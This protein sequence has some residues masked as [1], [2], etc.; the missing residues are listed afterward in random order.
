MKKALLF[1]AMTAMALPM[2]AETDG[3]TYEAKGGYTFENL[4]VNA[5]G[6]GKWQ[7]YVGSIIPAQDKICSATAFG[8]KIYVASSADF[9]IDPES[10]KT[11]MVDGNALLLEFDYNTGEY[12]R[13]IDL[14]LDGEPYTGTLCANYID[15]DD[16]GHV[17]IYGVTFTP[18][19]EEGVATGLKIYTVD[20][21]TGALTLQC[22]PEIDDPAASQ[23]VDFCDVSGDIT[24]QQA[25]CVVMACPGNADMRPY[26]YAWYC[27]Q[28][29]TEFVGNLAGYCT[30][31][32]EET[33]PEQAS[34]GQCAQVTII[35]DADYEGSLFYIDGN[36]TYPAIYDT[37]GA[38]VT[39]FADIT[40]ADPENPVF[41]PIAAPCGAY[42]FTIGDDSFLMY[43]MEEHAKEQRN[44][45]RLCRYGTLGDMSTLEHFYDFPASAALND[46]LGQAYGG[47]RLHV[48]QSRIVTDANGKQA[49]EIL[50]YKTGNGMGLYRLAQ[51]GFS[52]GISAPVVENEN[53]PVEYFNLQGIRVDNPE[54]GLFIRRQGSN[55]TKVVL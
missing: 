30:L 41:Y 9:G 4:W 34:W 21:A 2:F 37:E 24:R 53:A 8:D 11:V 47:R 35:P 23:R 45:A 39:S 46:G 6:I 52:A 17:Y 16:F 44:R 50:T 36:S 7:S 13:S 49:A 22:A 29:G 18:L 5:T 10:G 32:I 15:V 40:E 19:S 27:E 54:N 42:E 25:S 1:A 12:I 3:A 48:L 33:F 14:T 26:V 38:M 28:G 20:L 51:D 31:E 43:G 55:V